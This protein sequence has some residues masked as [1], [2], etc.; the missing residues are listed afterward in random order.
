MKNEFAYNYGDCYK[1]D[2]FVRMRY[3]I[4]SQMLSLFLSKD[5]KILDIGCYDGS[6][7]EVLKKDFNGLEYIGVDADSTALDIAR[8]RG[9]KTFNINL[10]SGTLPFKKDSFDVI[11]VGEILEHLRD[12]SRTLKKTQE[13]LKPE[14]VILVSLPNECT[15]YHRLKVMFGRGI[16]GTGFAPGYH[17]HFP[18]L[19]QNEEFIG[20]HFKIFAKR[21]WY[22]L[23]VGGVLEKVISIMPSGFWIGVTNLL[24]SLFARGAIYLCKKR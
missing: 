13:I 22:H 2:K 19:K 9:V 20:E 6:M 24:P 15:F 8:R 17:L 7:F 3:G 23:G 18:T 21:Y 4:V 5:T 10:E 11:I 12:P 16:D 14:G 1:D